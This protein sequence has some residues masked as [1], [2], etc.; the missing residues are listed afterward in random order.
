M[1]KHCLFSLFALTI[2]VSCNE[3]SKKA[4]FYS[5]FYTINS[6]T[7]II[8]EQQKKID[9]E[10]G[11]TFIA[12]GNLYVANTTEQLKMFRRLYKNAEKTDYCCCPEENY[13]ISFY[14]SK[15]QFDSYAVDTIE[16]KDKIRIY[17][18]DFQYSFIIDKTLWNNFLNKTNIKQ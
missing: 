4:E 1:K 2:F 12:N 10:F 15:D 8:I 3:I 6:C 16:F 17:E 9:A 7:K 5:H 13:I 14:S 18:R 11:E